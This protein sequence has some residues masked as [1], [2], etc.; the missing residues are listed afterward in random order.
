MKDS[1][2]VRVHDSFG[3]A[4]RERE[5]GREI[6]AK[7]FGAYNVSWNIRKRERGREGKRLLPVVPLV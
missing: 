3:V 5:G 4:C 1:R 2:T 7:V 6:K